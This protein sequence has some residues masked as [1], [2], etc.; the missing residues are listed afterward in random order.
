MN[1]KGTVL[2]SELGSIPMKLELPDNQ[3]HLL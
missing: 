2:E 3:L 1:L